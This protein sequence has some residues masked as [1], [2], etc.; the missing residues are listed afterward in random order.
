MPRSRSRHPE[1]LLGLRSK[2]FAAI[3]LL[4]LLAVGVFALE[5][6]LAAGGTGDRGLSE[7]V[8]RLGLTD[9]SLWTEARYTRHPSQADLFSAFQDLPSAPDHFPAG[10]IVF[11]PP[12]L[13]P[14]ATG[15]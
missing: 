13:H 1:A 3:V 8:G 4:E 6:S 10:S 5:A 12:H 15:R 11:P 2:L 7:L 9:L 14:G